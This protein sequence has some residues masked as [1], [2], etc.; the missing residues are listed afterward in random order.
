MAS[1]RAARSLS[2]VC[3]ISS[4]LCSLLEQVWGER[5]REREGR[6]RKRERERGG[7]GRGRE[8]ETERERGGGQKKQYMLPAQ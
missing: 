1:R 4:K 8:T 5:E 2:V 6:E 3:L 7:R